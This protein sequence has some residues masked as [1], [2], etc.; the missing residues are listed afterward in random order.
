MKSSLNFTNTV[1]GITILVSVYGI[2]ISVT[3]TYQKKVIAE[4]QKTIDSL[5][6]QVENYKLL[7]KLGE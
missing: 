3:A 6:V 7:Y 4:Q 5:N 2:A 1:M